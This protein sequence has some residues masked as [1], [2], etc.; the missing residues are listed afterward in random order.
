MESI[1]ELQAVEAECLRRFRVK[2]AELKAQHPEW[3]QQIAFA[4]SVTLLVKTADRYQ[5]ARMLLQWR[6]IPALPLR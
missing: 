5:H 6:G 1:E 2:A 4:K 3:T